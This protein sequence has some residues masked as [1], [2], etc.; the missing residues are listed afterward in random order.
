[1]EAELGRGDG[2]VLGWLAAALGLAY[3]AYVLVASLMVP[4]IL[5]PFG[6]ESFE[7]PAFEMQP[8]ASSGLD[9]PV[10]VHLGRPGAPVVLVFVGNYGAR[11]AF[12]PLFEPFVEAGHTVLLAPYRGA[13]GLPGPKTE[14]QFKADALAVFDAIPE[15]APE[16][17]AVHV[18]GY[19]MGSGLALHVAAHRAA[20]SVVLEAPFARLCDVMTR[21]S[22]APACL[23]PWV[24]RWDNLALV[25]DIFAPVFIVQG[26]PD[27]IIPSSES[28]RLAEAFIAN[29]N[30]VATRFDAAADHWSVALIPGLQEE[31]RAWIDRGWAEAKGQSRAEARAGFAQAG[32]RS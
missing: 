23:I 22:W 12:G 26:I 9:L 15:L 4:T 8:V 31:L 19:S 14:A 3:A 27:A 10:A 5:Y 21:K 13:E 25:T 29:G 28:L 16:A 7:H 6:Q 32:G 2:S 30:V 11:G 17:G 20:A 24:P 1:M 18:L